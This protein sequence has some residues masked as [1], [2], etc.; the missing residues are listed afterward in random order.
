MDEFLLSP[1]TLIEH[2]GRVHCHGSKKGLQRVSFGITMREKKEEEGKL[3][4]RMGYTEGE[5][6][7]V[8]FVSH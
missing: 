1:Q 4:K 7:F 6:S 8:F 3:S 5:P 2:P